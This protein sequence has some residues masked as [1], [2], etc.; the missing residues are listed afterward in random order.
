MDYVLNGLFDSFCTIYSEKKIAKELWKSLDQQYRTED[1]G[2]NKF[3]M[4]G[5]FN[6]KMVDA[7]TMISQVQEL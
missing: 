5:F 1:V 2:S 3:V 7:K 6:Y 4:S